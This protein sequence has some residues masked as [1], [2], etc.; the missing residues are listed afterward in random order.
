L[1][2]GAAADGEGAAA[3]GT[4][5]GGTAGVG[6][7]LGGVEAAADK[8]TRPTCQGGGG[9]R[10]PHGWLLG[11]DIG[12]GGSSEGVAVAGPVPRSGGWRAIC[13]SFD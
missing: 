7:E 4:A 6:A 2:S 3:G 13:S 5:A 10:R 11:G 9:H 12:P 1:R 8:G